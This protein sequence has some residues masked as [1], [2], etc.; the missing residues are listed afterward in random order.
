M[1]CPVCGAEMQKGGLIADARWL[2]WA[3]ADKYEKG[4]RPAYDGKIK[5]GRSS[6]LLRETRVPDAYY[7][8][9]CK[10]VTGIFDVTEAD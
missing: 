2:I 6:T 1:K 9:N 5:L 3:P 7:C 8:G 10:K 4:W